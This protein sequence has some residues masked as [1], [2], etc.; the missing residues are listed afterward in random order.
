MGT[1]AEPGVIPRLCEGIFERFTHLLAW[2]YHR[3]ILQ[4]ES[5]LLTYKVEASYMEIYNEKVW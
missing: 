3:R 5:N 2:T 4:N 1:D